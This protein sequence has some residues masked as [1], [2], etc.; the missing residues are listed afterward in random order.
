MSKSFHTLKISKI[1]SETDDTV[2]VSFAVPADLKDAFQYTQGQYLTLKFDINGEEHRRAYSMSSSPI[3]EDIT[4]TIKRVKGGVV[5]NYIHDKLSQGSTVDVMQPDGRFYSKLDPNHRKSYY[6]FA[7]GS[8]IT[9]LMSIATT[10][11]EKEGQSSVSLLY[12]NRNEDTIIF[13]DKLDTYSK[14]YAGQFKL[15]YILSKPKTE[16]KSGLGGLFKK[17]KPT[18]TGQIGRIGTEEVRKFLDD[19]KSIYSDSVYFICGP[20]NMIDTVEAYLIQ[21]GAEKANIFTERFV[22]AKKEGSAAKMSAASSLGGA[23]VTYILNGEENSISVP[24]G[25]TI[26]AEMIDQKLEPP[27]SCTSGACSTCMAKM[28]S[29][30]VNMEVCYALDDDEIAA[31]YI[32]CCQAQAVSEEVSINFDV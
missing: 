6:M 29:G 25:K 30:K 17:A 28:T 1:E 20:G 8:G 4:V 27:Y 19:N 18:W 14:K 22:S 32:L 24:K 23:R 21:Q 12:G 11:L 26:L 31:G 7:A 2:S 10:I 13:K 16:K 9:P 15:S 3:E 5:S